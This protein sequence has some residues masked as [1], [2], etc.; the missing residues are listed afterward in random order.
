MKLRNSG[1]SGKQNK[2]ITVN[3]HILPAHTMKQY[4]GRE[5]GGGKTYLA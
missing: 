4:V 1:V 2:Y 3:G 5:E